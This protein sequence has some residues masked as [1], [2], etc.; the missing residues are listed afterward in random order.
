MEM[1]LQN[2]RGAVERSNYLEQYPTD[3]RTAA[4]I[5]NLAFLDGN[6]ESKTIADLG[7]GNGLF[8]FGALMYGA[9]RS[10]CVEIDSNLPVHRNSESFPDLDLPGTINFS[11]LSYI[12]IFM[13]T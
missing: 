4:N 10:Y 9:T 3:P 2:L 5:L 7:S 11:S 8:G 1:R 6:I 13:E 12:G